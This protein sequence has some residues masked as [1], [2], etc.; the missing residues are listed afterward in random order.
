[1][2]L[3]D[4]EYIYDRVG[5][6]VE[7]RDWR[8]ASEWKAVNR[9]STCDD[10]YLLTKVEYTCVTQKGTDDWVEP[11]AA[12][13]FD[14]SRPQPSPR[15]DTAGVGR[16]L[17]QSWALLIGFQI[18]WI[19]GLPRG[20]REPRPS[21]RNAAIRIPREVRFGNTSQNGL[22]RSAG[23]AVLGTPGRVP[24]RS[25]PEACATAAGS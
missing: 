18:R 22:P 14:N 11:Y 8:L 1:M 15:G 12:E 6:P 2:L 10:L 24:A 19:L 13:V 21:P 16:P 20:I 25:A 4:D 3:Q 9:K 17:S 23:R 5:N 7:I